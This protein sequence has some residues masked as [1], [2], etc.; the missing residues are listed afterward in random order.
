MIIFVLGSSYRR[1]NVLQHGIAGLVFLVSLLRPLLGIAAETK[2]AW[3]KDWEAALSG[4]Q[5][6]GRVVLYGS[7][8]Y[9]EI[10]REFQKKYPGIK[11][12]AVTG[13]TPELAERILAE[14]RAGKYLADLYLGGSGPA[15]VLLQAKALDPVKPA[16]LLPEVTDGSKWWKGRHVY[17]DSERQYILAFNGIAQSY[18]SR[19]TKLVKANEIHSYWDLLRPQWKG[20]IVAMDPTMGGGV[21][22]ALQ[23]IYLNPKLGREFLRR[24][25]TEMDI[26]PTRDLRQFSD[27]LAV[28]KFAIGALAPPDRV[29]IYE[30]KEQGLPVDVFESRSFSEGIPLSTSSGNLGLIAGAPH[31]QAAKIAINWF[32]SREG[33]RVYQKAARDKDSLRIDIPK[34]DV[35]PHVRRVEGAEYMVLAGPEFQ[36]QES[37]LK[38][39][40]EIWKGRK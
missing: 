9:E 5:K 20:K 30:A 33:Q 34:D 24:F 2:A 17:H 36:D 29:G 18:F 27:W 19:N 11:V 39:V 21:G 37:V 12:N 31:P 40:N 35:L 22:G 28:G 38:V 4:A 23:S 3:Q 7:V 25:L 6:E 15:Y 8:V 1:K 10:F 14:R 26:T 13:R 16:L 32:L